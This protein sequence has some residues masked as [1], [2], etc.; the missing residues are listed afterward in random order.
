METGASS[1][2]ACG[3]GASGSG[4]S[5]QK[6]LPTPISLST[7][8]SPP[9]SVTSWRQIARPSPVPP[10][11]SRIV[12]SAWEKASKM[13]PRA[14]GAMPMPVSLTSK[15]TMSPPALRTWIETVPSAVNLTALAARL[16]RTSS[17]WRRPPLTPWGR[18]SSTSVRKVSPLDRAWATTIDA[19]SATASRRAKGTFSAGIRPT[20]RREKSR[21]VLMWASR[22]RPAVETVRF[23]SVWSAS[24]RVSPSRSDMPM[25]AFSGV[26]SSWLTEAMNR[27]LARLAASASAFAFC[28]FTSRERE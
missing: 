4:S 12:S 21:M 1:R 10:K 18:S 7:P 2:T 19:A 25:M 8:I 14:S 27:L 23:I 11:L 20:S 24:R 15:R 26:R 17:R 28:S 6:V 16:T 9:C 3:R 22:A 5:N 13:R